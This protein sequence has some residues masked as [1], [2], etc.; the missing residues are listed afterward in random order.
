M[1]VPN[2]HIRRDIEVLERL[3]QAVSEF[4]RREERMTRALEVRRSGVTWRYQSAMSGAEEGEKTQMAEMDAT[5]GEQEKRARRVAANRQAR[6]ERASAQ[7][8]R[9]MPRKSREAR[10]NWLANLQM[11]LRQ[12]ET[13]RAEALR[14]AEAEAA[15]V[16][17]SLGQECERVIALKRE[18]KKSLRSYAKL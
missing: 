2:L 10:G 5:F 11:R 12:A 17:Q 13:A 1:T 18:A 4:A 9:S 15:A 3:K 8:L 16:A 14:A 7:L 6:V